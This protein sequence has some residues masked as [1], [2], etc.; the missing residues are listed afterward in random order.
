[1]TAAGRPPAVDA[2]SYPRKSGI[3][4]AVSG[5]GAELLARF[6]PR[7]A[8]ASWPATEA[9]RQQVLARLLAPP[10]ALDH[11]FSQQSRRL[12]LVT[13]LNWLE[14]QPGGSWQ[15]R[16]QASGAEDRAD[17]R[18]LVAAWKAGRAGP[19]PVSSGKPPPHIGPGSAGADLR[20][21]DPARLR[22]VA[23]VP[24]G[25]A[26][27]GRRD[28]PHSRRCRV[29]RA[30]R[31]VPVRFGGI[32]RPAGRARAG[33]GHHGGQGRCPGRHYR[34]RLRAA[35]ERR[36]RGAHR[37]GPAPAQPVLLPAAARLGRLRPGRAGGDAGARQPGEA[38][39]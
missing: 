31:V 16:W 11:P 8:V 18:D 36:R 19:A 10:F 5:T 2:V 23:E 1:M 39:V 37:E 12:G 6:P 28:G 29:C 9:T 32:V 7:P 38:D 27:P 25:T 17:W 35:A 3:P 34:R 4:Q 33:R 21:R 26:Q 13:V 30:D 14:A 24:V 15:D 22:V 20:R